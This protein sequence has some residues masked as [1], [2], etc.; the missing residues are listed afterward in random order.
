[1]PLNDLSK[2]YSSVQ[3]VSKIVSNLY[4]KINV[5]NKVFRDYF[6]VD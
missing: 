5:D 6:Y 1:M 2:H 4:V 3:V